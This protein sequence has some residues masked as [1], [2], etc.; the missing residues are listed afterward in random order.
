M[1]KTLDEMIAVMQAAKE[2]KEIESR[3]LHG[4]YIVWDACLKP[5][6]DWKCFEYRVKPVEPDNN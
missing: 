5:V 3:A 2:G 4:Q 1:S 6:W